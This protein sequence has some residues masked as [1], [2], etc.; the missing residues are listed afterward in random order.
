MKNVIAFFA[1]IGLVIS[2]QEKTKTDYADTA[3]IVQTTAQEHPG[4]QL[5]ESK[6]NICHNATT[7]MENRI[8]PPMIAIKKH[9]IG[10]STTKEQFTKELLAWAKAP[11]EENAKMPGAIVKF[12]VMPYQAF[13]DETISLIADYIYENEIEQPEWFEQ[14]FNEERGAR[15]GKGMGKGMRKGKS[16]GRFN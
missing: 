4:K 13:E 7:P 11:S 5:M 14:H 12:G 3:A 1:L 8:A 10:E 2:C 15:R 9:Y 16:T 6:C